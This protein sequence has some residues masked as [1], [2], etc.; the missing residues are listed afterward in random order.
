MHA[1]PNSK[2]I[3]GRVSY[4]ASRL[5]GFIDGTLR[6]IDGAHACRVKL[7]AD[8]PLF[9]GHFPGRPV[10]PGVIMIEGLVALVERATGSQQLLS[11]IVEA[12]FRSEAHPNDE[13]DYVMTPAADGWR[14]EVK[15]GER[16][17]LTARLRLTTP[18]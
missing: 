18:N 17:V 4:R 13:L 2:P 15:I 12:K 10:V 16:E 14:A 1:E 5:Y 11:H 7:S 3:S 9:K 8:E 6:T